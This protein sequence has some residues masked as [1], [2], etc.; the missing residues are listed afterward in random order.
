MGLVPPFGCCLRLHEHRCL[1]TLNQPVDGEAVAE[2]DGRPEGTSAP[3]STASRI[4]SEPR[5]IATCALTGPQS[6]LA[7][8]GPDAEEAALATPGEVGLRSQGRDL[9]HALRRPGDRRLDE[10]RVDQRAGLQAP[11]PSRRAADSPERTVPLR[12]HIRPALHGSGKAS[13]GPWPTSSSSD[14][15]SARPKLQSR[16][17]RN[18]GTTDGRPAPPRGQDQKAGTAAPATAREPSGN[19]RRAVTSASGG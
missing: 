13:S 12:G 15:P 3:V 17:R 11:P 2:T 18:G 19:A 14:V 5:A 9:A 10:R 1:V 16:S 4:R 8:M 7:A 6:R